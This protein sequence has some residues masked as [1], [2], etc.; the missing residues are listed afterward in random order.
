MA[1]LSCSWR[2][3]VSPKQW[4][5]CTKVHS[6]VSRKTAIFKLIVFAR[7]GEHFYCAQY[8][9]IHTSMCSVCQHRQDFLSSV[10]MTSH[11]ITKLSDNRTKKFYIANAK[12]YHWPWSW[13]SSI[14]VPKNPPHIVL[15][16][17]IQVLLLLL[18]A[19]ILSKPYWSLPIGMLF[20]QK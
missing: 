6:T 1:S 10:W 3:E 17:V 12:A 16:S 20:A 5:L 14:H 13:A 19:L 9:N 15:F 4:N 7:L 8:L 2:Q 11:H 18:R